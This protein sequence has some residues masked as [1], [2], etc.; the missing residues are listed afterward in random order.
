M[1]FVLVEVSG[2]VKHIRP[3]H[4]QV[5]SIKKLKIPWGKSKMATPIITVGQLQEAGADTC[6]FMLFELR[7]GLGLR[8]GLRSELVVEAK[9]FGRGWSFG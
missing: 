8:M 9:S 1:L 4:C 7:L 5:K 3:P 6:R 2:I